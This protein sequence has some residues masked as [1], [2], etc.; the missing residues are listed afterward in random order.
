MDPERFDAF[1]RSFGS[2]GTRRRLLGGLLGSALGLV[3]LRGAA[4]VTCRA[5]GSVCLHNGNCCSGVCGPT[6]ATGRHRCLCRAGTE[7]CH[8]TCVDPANAYQS[9]PAN[10]GSC[11]H[12]CP[13]VAGGT[14]TCT[15]G[16]CGFV[17]APGY[18]AL[19]G[20]C[21]PE[22]N[23]CGPTCL[24]APCNPA[25]CLSCDSVAGACVSTC[26][27]EE[28][29][30]NGTCVAP[31]NPKSCADFPGQCGAISDGCGGTLSC[32]CSGGQT[33]QSGTC[34][35]PTGTCGSGCA[36]VQ[37]GDGS[38]KQDVGGSCAGGSDCCSGVCVSG[39]CASVPTCD[40]S[41]LNFCS[42]HGT[43]TTE[44]ICSCDSGYSG[45]DCAIPPAVDCSSFATC[46]D[47]QASAPAGCV[48]CGETFG[49][50]TQVCTT[51]DQCL[52][53]VVSCAA[54]DPCAGVT[55]GQCTTCVGGACVAANEGGTCTGNDA[56]Y[57]TYTCQ[58]GSCTPS[59]PVQCGTCETCS[60][61]S[62]VAICNASC[63]CGN[64]G[65]CNN[66]LCLAAC[67]GACQECSP[68]QG[69]LT[70]CGASYPGCSCPSGT[71]CD[72]RAE[73]CVG[74]CFVAGARIAMA[75]GTSQPIESVAVGD[76]VVGRDGVNRVLELFRPVLGERPLYALN[77][78]QPFVTAGHSFLTAE[79]WKAA[80][81]AATAAENPG[82]AVGRLAVGDRLLALAGVAVPALAAGICADDVEV[83]F[84]EVPLDRLVAHAAEP[85]TPLYNLRVDGDHTF[86]ANDLVVHNKVV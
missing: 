77:G 74:T 83:R 60:H 50:A 78:G 6:D 20:A 65:V 39:Q 24:A 30:Q 13:G 59:N 34:A 72:T 61:G 16:A 54:G 21:C 23:V 46:T 53:P 3:G 11:G 55:C 12:R 22:A 18:S 35:C 84:E 32:D 56:C 42:G 45:V 80:D 28:I 47:C 63:S 69:C 85:A 44:C 49:G 9:D 7:D 40:C 79:G 36:Q 26:A 41:N 70:H 67:T 14:A 82:L 57:Q 10:C 33:C 76:L 27:G 73:F 2:P 48:W 86:V 75:D 29:C 71:V 5:A 64:C 15:R 4:A 81:P 31:C 8:R 43:C 38:C 51:A 52:S 19:N 1:A 37:C 17:C 66:G 25:Q 58:A 62:C 68:T